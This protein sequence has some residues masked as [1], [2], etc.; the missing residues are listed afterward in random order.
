MLSLYTGVAKWRIASPKSPL[1]LSVLCALLAGAALSGCVYDPYYAV[2]D[3]APLALPYYYP[4]GY[5]Y[6]YGYPYGY[7]YARPAYAGPPITFNFG[8]SHYSHHDHG[9]GHY[10]GHGGSGWHG[11]GWGGGHG[12]Y[13][14]AHG[15]GHGGHGHR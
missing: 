6:T 7:G 9:H 1:P 12:G 3:P 2:H 14:G 8:Y 10:G 5:G 11:H 13:H 4:Y 15:G